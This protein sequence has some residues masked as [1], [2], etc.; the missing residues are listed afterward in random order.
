MGVGD[1]GEGDDTLF[2]G[3]GNDSLLSGDGDDLVEGGF[4]DDTLQ[5]GE[6][7]DRITYFKHTQGDRI[8][9]S[10]ID[11]PGRLELPLLTGGVD[12]NGVR[13]LSGALIEAGVR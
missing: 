4:G 5:A 13:E 3:E 10:A 7:R 12:L 2:G 8:D 1:A 9:L 11:A 6:G